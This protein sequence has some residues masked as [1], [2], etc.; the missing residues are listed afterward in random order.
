MKTVLTRLIERIDE[1]VSSEEGA[2]SNIHIIGIKKAA[3]SM[4]QD[5]KTQ[6][7]RDYVNGWE[8]MRKSIANDSYVSPESYF[9]K[10][11]SNQ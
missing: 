9:N 8:S 1:M 10:I 3:E 11:Y 7:M 5:E 6:C 2:S 4:L